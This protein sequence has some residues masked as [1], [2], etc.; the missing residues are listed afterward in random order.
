MFSDIESKPG[1]NNPA[2]VDIDDAVKDR[3]ASY[4]DLNDERSYFLLCRRI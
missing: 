2:W 4:N 3:I 1:V